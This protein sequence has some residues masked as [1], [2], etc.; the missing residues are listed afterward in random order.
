MIFQ[1]IL[2]NIKKHP[3]I[4]IN[5]KIISENK[6]LHQIFTIAPYKN[7]FSDFYNIMCNTF[8]F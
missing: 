1:I 8:F 3:K 5:L 2:L 6:N 4:V 7:L